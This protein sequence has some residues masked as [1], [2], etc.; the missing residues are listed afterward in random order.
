MK[1]CP[2][3]GCVPPTRHP[4]CHSQCDGYKEW[5]KEL[6][7]YNENIRKQKQI[8]NDIVDAKRSLLRLVKRKRKC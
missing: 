4:G 3:I 1:D 8:D 6:D 5:R 7:A 2:C